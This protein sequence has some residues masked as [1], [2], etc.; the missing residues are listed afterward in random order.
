MVYK[1]RLIWLTAALTAMIAVGAGYL[2]RQRARANQVQ[3]P[4]L[5]ATVVEIPASAIEPAP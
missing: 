3:A 2:A 5:P 1:L 4:R